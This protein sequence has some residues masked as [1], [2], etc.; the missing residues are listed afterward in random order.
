MWLRRSLSLVALIALTVAQTVLVGWPDL[1]RTLDLLSGR[2][3]TGATEFAFIAS[4]CWLM[5]AVMVVVAAV[6]A[7]RQSARRPG[8]VA[9][10]LLCVAAVGLGIGL[11]SAGIANRQNAYS[12]CCANPGTVHEAEQL[13]R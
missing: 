8:T 1:G 7:V 4:L 3:L 2:S 9:R 6:D 13:V 12:V 5:L 11:L 10:R